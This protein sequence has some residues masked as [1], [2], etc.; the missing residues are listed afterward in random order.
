MTLPK[1]QPLPDE[2]QAQVDR[3][4]AFIAQCDGEI[5][6]AQKAVDNWTAQ[7]AAAQAQVK[8]LRLKY[9]K[10]DLTVWPTPVDAEVMP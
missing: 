4:L 7:R 6:A 3:Q 10:P 8:T 2:I 5:L 9:A 1:I